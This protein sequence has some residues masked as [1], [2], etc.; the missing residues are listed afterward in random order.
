MFNF[1]NLK[2]SWIPRLVQHSPILTLTCILQ[3]LSFLSVCSPIKLLLR[4]DSQDSLCRM[5]PGGRL[6]YNCLPA[7]LD[8][9]VGGE[10]ASL[11]K[12]FRFWISWTFLF[13]PGKQARQVGRF[14]WNSL[15]AHL[16]K[17]Y[18]LY[19]QKYIYIGNL[20]ALIYAITL[21]S[22]SSLLIIIYS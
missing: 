14:T 22:F 21:L 13:S 10:G 11:L 19:W 20:T 18:F 17:L 7:H 9:C 4:S 2:Y 6:D 12:L 8:R 15:L 3:F 5:R 1:Q 16:T